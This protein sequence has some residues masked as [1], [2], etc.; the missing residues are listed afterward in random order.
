MDVL[1][2]LLARDR[3]SDAPALRAPATGREY[4]YRRFCTTAWKVGNF[5]RHFGVYDGSTVALATNAQPGSDSNAE[6]EPILAFL[7]TALLGGVARFEPPQDTDARVLIRPSPDS[8]LDV[9]MD[10]NTDVDAQYDLPEG[11]QRIVYGDSS[12]DPNIAHFEQGVWSENPT[13]PPNTVEAEQPLLRCNGTTY[14]HT[15][16]LD[17]ARSVVD[18]WDLTAKDRVAIRASLNEPETVV[19]GVVAPLL[20]GGTILLPDEQSVGDCAVADTAPEPRVLSPNAIEFSE[21]VEK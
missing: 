12:D 7:G 3:R 5:V 1:G 13:K 4:D 18:A 17:S 2:D 11:S 16:V 9:D 14:T 8:D 20:A 15:D 10:A 19:A 21:G 6:P